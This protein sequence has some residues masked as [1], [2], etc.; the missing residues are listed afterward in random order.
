[1]DMQLLNKRLEIICKRQFK[2]QYE[3]K[4]NWTQTNAELKFAEQ[5]INAW[6]F[7]GFRLEWIDFW[8]FVKQ[9]VAHTF[10]TST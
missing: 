2:Y 4:M 10:S 1:M 6:T 9:I 8:N 3:K 5:V 7:D